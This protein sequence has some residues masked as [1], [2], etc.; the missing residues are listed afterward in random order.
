MPTAAGAAVGLAGVV[1][2]GVGLWGWRETRRALAQERIVSPGDGS[3]PGAPVTDA[4]AARSLAEL[5]RRN[6]VDATGGRTYAEVEPY[7][8]VNG[9]PSSDKAL[10]AKDERTGQPVENPDHDLW[11]Q[12]TALQTGLM[13]AYMAFRLSELTI[14][15]GAAFVASGAGL[16]A[17]GRRAGRSRAPLYASS[18]VRTTAPVS[19][20]DPCAEAL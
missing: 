9:K 5:I 3:R 2:V 18:T 20:G 17:A 1:F 11:I 14:A 10:A 13:Q 12:S 16:V 6:T 7:V 4:T 19:S 15:L 8:D